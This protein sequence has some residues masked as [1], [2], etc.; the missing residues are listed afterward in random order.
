M[1]MRKPA[2]KAVPAQSSAPIPVLPAVAEQAAPLE[3]AATPDPVLETVVEPP[4]APAEEP[5]QWVKMAMSLEGQISLKRGD[6]HEFPLSHAISMR[7][8]GIG[9]FCDAPDA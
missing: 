4:A 7:D 3:P 9:E 8:A 6:S 5:K 2:K 1:V